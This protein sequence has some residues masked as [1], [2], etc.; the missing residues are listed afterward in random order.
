VTERLYPPG[1]GSSGTSAGLN[2]PAR[3]CHPPPRLLRD[4]PRDAGGRI[5]PELELAA[6]QFPLGRSFRSSRTRPRWTTTPFTDTGRTLAP[7]TGPPYPAATG[8]LSAEPL[9][10]SGSDGR[11]DK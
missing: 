6:G 8:T 11:A 1:M 5:F 3:L 10:R 7:T 4:L 9:C 2:S